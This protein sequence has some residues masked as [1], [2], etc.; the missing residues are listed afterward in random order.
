MHFTVGYKKILHWYKSIQEYHGIF[1]W[2]NLAPIKLLVGK[3][4]DFNGPVLQ[5]RPDAGEGIV[6]GFVEVLHGPADKTA[7]VRSPMVG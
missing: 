1:L 4:A 5:E 2:D 6:K 3:I 7:T